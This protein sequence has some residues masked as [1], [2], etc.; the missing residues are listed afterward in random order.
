MVDTYGL[1]M[2]EEDNF[3]SVIPEFSNCGATDTATDE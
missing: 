3:E 2:L 1:E